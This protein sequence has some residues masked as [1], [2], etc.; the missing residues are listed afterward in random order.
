MDNQAPEKPSIDG[1]VNGKILKRYTYTA[2][3]TDPDGDDVSYF[4]DW[5]DGR[6]SDWTNFVASGTTVSRSHTWLKEG[7]YTVSVKAKDVH[8]AESQ[9]A[10]LQVTMPKN[11]IIES[12]LLLRFLE[13]FPLFERF[14]NSI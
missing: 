12:S 5:G 6:T 4:F 7:T 14:L 11:K 13:R 9:W 10:T 8:G 3:T 1:P 2:V